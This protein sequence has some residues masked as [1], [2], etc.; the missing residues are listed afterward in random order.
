[1]VRNEHMI[2]TRLMMSHYM[3]FLP[4]IFRKIVSVYVVTKFVVSL[5][6]GELIHYRSS[7]RLSSKAQMT[8]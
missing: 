4:K 7:W 1:M 8:L 2:E 3:N 5:G 6:L